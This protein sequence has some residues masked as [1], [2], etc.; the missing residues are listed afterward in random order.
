MNWLHRKLDRTE[1]ECCGERL[2]AYIDRELAPEERVTLERHLAECE[3]CRWNLETLRQTVEWTRSSAP[4]RLPRVFTLPVASGA[5]QAARARR[6]AWGVPLLQGATALVA[7]LFV[8]VVAGDLFVGSSAFQSEPQMVAVR[9]TAAVDQSAPVQ[10]QATQM[11]QMQPAPTVVAEAVEAEPPSEPAAA[12]AP[13]PE[14]T[15]ALPAAAEALTMVA[16][17]ATA[18]AEVGGM[19]G[20]QLAAVSVTMEVTAAVVE[21]PFGAPR[22]AATP[23]ATVTLAFTAA[24]PLLT[25]LLTAQVTLTE[26]TTAEQATL[27]ALTSTATEVPAALPTQQLLMPTAEAA[28]TEVPEPASMDTVVLEAVQGGETMAATEEG[29]SAAAP[30]EAPAAMLSGPDPTVIAA[31]PEAREVEQADGS[32]EEPG[33]AGTLRETVAPWFSLAE[34]VL[35]AVFVLLALTTAVIMLRRQPR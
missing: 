1:D 31:A 13:L 7:L 2:S 17:T 25:Q 8:V 26:W 6:P 34:I 3:D 27:Q 22:V 9:A 29:Y 4:V 32:G 16:P 19:G 33:A 12:K 15:A 18:V 23:T 24:M 28:V 10:L 30:T 14:M 11:A 20:G 21:A 35:G 5:P